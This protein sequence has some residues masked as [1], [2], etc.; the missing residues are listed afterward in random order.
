MFGFRGSV[1]AMTAVDFEYHSFGKAGSGYQGASFARMSSGQGASADISRSAIWARKTAPL[2]FATVVLGALLHRFGII[3]VDEM[4]SVLGAGA[5]LALLSVG[6]SLNAFIDIW[7][8]GVRGFFRAASAL[9]ISLVTLAPF[10]LVVLALLY[11]PKVNGVTTNALDPPLMLADIA[12]GRVDGQVLEAQ[13]AAY[14]ALQTQEFPLPTPQVY[15]LARGAA[16]RS[17]LTITFELPPIVV[18]KAADIEEQSIASVGLPKPK[19]IV[20]AD[21]S[22]M[23]RTVAK[24][25]TEASAEGVFEAVAKTPVLGFIDD[26]VVRVRATDTGSSVDVRSTSRIGN[27]DL[28]TNARRVQG[29]LRELDLSVK[30]TT[31]Q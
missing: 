9:V 4:L 7:Q 15:D 18:T 17:G 19:P 14:P 21:G 31:V 20:L 8:L 5:F 3:P 30:A 12:F 11:L 16:Q 29:F 24:F 1:F 28:G 27:H 2:G 25:Y 26:F 6:M 22:V 10:V 23:Q 13:K